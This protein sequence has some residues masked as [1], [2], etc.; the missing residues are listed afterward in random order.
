MG[1][2]RTLLLGDVGNRL[3]IE[4]CERDIGALQRKLRANSKMD[5][6]Q[7]DELAALR[8]EVDEL[9]LVVGSLTRILTSKGV[10]DEAELSRFA[11]VIDDDQVIE[12]L[13][14]DPA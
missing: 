3:D 11:R 6:N 5:R 8:E 1:W 4:D 10:V 12:Y 13:D 14:D 9:K 2:G 7:D